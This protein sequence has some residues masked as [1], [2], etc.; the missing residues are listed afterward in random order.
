MLV[1]GDA[2]RERGVEWGHALKAASVVGDDSVIDAFDRGSDEEQAAASTMG[3]KERSISYVKAFAEGGYSFGPESTTTDK[4]RVVATWILSIVFPIFPAI[5]FLVLWI[6]DLV[7][8]L[9]NPTPPNPDDLEAVE[10]EEELA[11]FANLGDELDFSSVGSGAAATEEGDGEPG[12]DVELVR[13]T[14]TAA[15]PRTPP[16]SPLLVRSSQGGTTP[17]SDAAVSAHAAAAVDDLLGA[18]PS[19]LPPPM[20]PEGAS[21]AVKPAVVAAVP[22]ARMLAHSPLPAADGSADSTPTAA[23]PPV[24]PDAPGLAQAHA[25][26]LLI[27]ASVGDANGEAT[28]AREMLARRE[29]PSPSGQSRAS[30]AAAPRSPVPSASAARAPSPIRREVTRKAEH[31]PIQNFLSGIT[32][33]NARKINTIVKTLATGSVF[34]LPGLLAYERDQELTAMNPFSFMAFIL[35]QAEL[36]EALPKIKARGSIMGQNLWVKFVSG[37]RDKKDTMERAEPGSWNEGVVEFERFCGVPAG[38]FQF[39]STREFADA[40]LEHSTA[41]YDRIQGMIARAAR[42]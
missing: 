4:V 39:E 42:R 9:T 40:I 11:A 28:L 32:T 35:S 36:L 31:R 20:R 8:A 16:G 13:R 6:T 17:R 7:N 3:G 38:T 18:L 5:T 23:A 14:A 1:S 22:V 21:S 41:I 24:F 2:P 10:G 25:M 15:S 12:V 19:D 33:A 30:S 37:I 29:S 34:T 27:S 26:R